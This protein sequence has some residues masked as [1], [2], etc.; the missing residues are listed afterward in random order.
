MFIYKLS[1][2][3]LIVFIRIYKYILALL[4]INAERYIDKF[5][6]IFRNINDLINLKIKFVYVM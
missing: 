6:L 2:Y 4:L 1:I 5:Y 3:I